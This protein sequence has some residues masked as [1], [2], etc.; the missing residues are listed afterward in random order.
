MASEEILAALRLVLEED[1]RLSSL[2]E[3]LGSLEDKFAALEGKVDTLAAR[4]GKNPLTSL[5]ESIDA[6][7]ALGRSMREGTGA[8]AS[9]AA[10]QGGGSSGI[11]P[12]SDAPS[13]SFDLGELA[14]VW[15]SHKEIKLR[16]FP[17]LG[18]GKDEIPYGRW[19]F[20][21]LADADAARLSPV[22]QAELPADAPREVEEF[23]RAA[24]AVLYA[25]LLN[26][27]K[28]ISVLSD[29][30][31]RLYGKPS[32]ARQA[33]LAIKAHYVRLSVNNRTYLLKKLQELEPVGAESMEAF[34]NR[35]AKLRND[36]AEYNLVCEDHLLITQ[37]VSKLSIQWKTRA[38]LDR[39]LESYSW[40]QVASALQTEDND[41]RQS[42]TKS[43]EA[44]M[45]LGWTRRAQGDARAATGD[46]QSS[47]TEGSAA[48]AAGRFGPPKGK[49]P[50]GSNPEGESKVSVPVVC[51]F[52]QG[53][54]HTFGECTTKP[55]G[56]KASAS[57]KAKAEQ[58]REEMRRKK[59]QSTRDKAAHAARAASQ[60]T[61]SEPAEARASGDL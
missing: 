49:G 29:I 44:L 52:C 38:G 7:I 5:E 20:H 11:H 56:W 46:E 60:A 33:W 61:E 34:L 10:P 13:S 41:R 45:P 39:P 25:G 57:D 28:E 9:S 36:F 4:Q 51:W 14:A 59:L 55:A 18:R 31:L 1:P 27:V 23:Y 15:Q 58:A 6:S 3:Q 40:D 22:L 47:S 37:V 54:G 30:V 48:P 53:V 12:D 50:K 42:N 17:K 24:N 35:C 32:S 21:V 26:S 16:S 43:P 19:K 2:G 8:G